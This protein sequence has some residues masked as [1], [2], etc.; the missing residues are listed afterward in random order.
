MG[1]GDGLLGLL[2]ERV[3]ASKAHAK[4]SQSVGYSSKQVGVAAVLRAGRRS[5]QLFASAVRVT[6]LR[7]EFPG[8]RTE[9]RVYVGPGCDVDLAPGSTVTLRGCSLLGNVTLVTGPRASIDLGASVVGRGSVIAAR[10]RITIGIDS[11]LAEMVVV[12]DANHDRPLTSGMFVSAAVSI[13]REVWLGAQSTVL[14]GVTIGDEATIGAG[15]V[16]TRN[17]PPRSTAVGV[18]ARV[19]DVSPVSMCVTEVR[20]ES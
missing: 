8:F 3:G 6:L 15:A 9:G 20:P 1:N 18:P 4:L 12:R 2:V 13:G 11:K 5:R 17:V 14:A 7:L 10:E 16:V 19:R